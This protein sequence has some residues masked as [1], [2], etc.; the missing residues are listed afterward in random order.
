LAFK[1]FENNITSRK[2]Q[3]EDIT[4]DL[5]R[6]LLDL[7]IAIKRIQELE[8]EINKTIVY[9][10]LAKKKISEL[11]E[12]KVYLNLALQRFDRLEEERG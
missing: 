5:E 12:K 3:L 6:K 11:E 2:V 7:Q 4:K 1:K 8:K 10:C 9:K